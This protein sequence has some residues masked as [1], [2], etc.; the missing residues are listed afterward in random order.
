MKIFHK[1]SIT[2][3]NFFNFEN[4]KKIVKVLD[5]SCKCKIFQYS[6]AH[7]LSYEALKK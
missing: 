3:S 5:I 1:I 4:I 7:F 6:C 2:L